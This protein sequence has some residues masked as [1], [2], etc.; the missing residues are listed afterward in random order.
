MYKISP[1]VY[2]KNDPALQELIE[3]TQVCNFTDE[4]LASY[5]SGLKVLKYRVDFKRCRRKAS[6]EVE[7][8]VSQK[9]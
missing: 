1:S 5:E 7:P 6:R 2:E 3:H 8:K 4:E 9:A